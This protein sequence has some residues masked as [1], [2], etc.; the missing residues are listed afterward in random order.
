M[1]P[2][3]RMDEGYLRGLKRSELQTLARVRVA[4]NLYSV[5]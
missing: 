1:T 3:L 5:A 4:P 2:V